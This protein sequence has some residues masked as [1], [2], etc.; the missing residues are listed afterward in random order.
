MGA[1][2]NSRPFVTTF[3]CAPLRVPHCVQVPCRWRTR[4]S[5]NLKEG[6]STKSY[7]HGNIQRNSMVILDAKNAITIL[8]VKL[9]I[10]GINGTT[11]SNKVSQQRHF[12][13]EK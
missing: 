8:L 11:G 5:S 10:V 6:I 13:L 9:G 12:A 7:Q 2:G 4:C 3:E 1:D